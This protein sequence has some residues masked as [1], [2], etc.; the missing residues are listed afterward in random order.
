[1][2]QRAAVAR[3]RWPFRPQFVLCV[4]KTW[5]DR[6]DGV[7]DSSELEWLWLGAPQSERRYLVARTSG[8]IRADV[9]RPGVSST[10]D[11]TSAVLYTRSAVWTEWWRINFVPSQLPL[12]MRIYKPYRLTIE[13]KPF[14]GRFG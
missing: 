7:F 8:S 14:L 11:V 9:V 2:L 3:R 6:M 13:D 10:V 4:P 12:H 1:M 5:S